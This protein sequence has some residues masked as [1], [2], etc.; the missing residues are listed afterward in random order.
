MQFNP[1]RRGLSYILPLLSPLP[2]Q[3][4]DRHVRYLVFRNCRPGASFLNAVASVACLPAAAAR[5]AATL[6]ST[7]RTAAAAAAAVVAVRPTSTDD[8]RHAFVACRVAHA[9]AASS[10]GRVSCG[11]VAS[12]TLDLIPKDALWKGNRPT[13]PPPTPE[14]EAAGRA[15]A[16]EQLR[17][18][19]ARRFVA[20]AVAA[21]DSTAWGDE[22]AAAAAAAAAECGGVWATALPFSAAVRGRRFPVKA[23]ALAAALLVRAALSLR[24]AASQRRVQVRGTNKIFPSFRPFSPA[25]GGIEFSFSSSGVRVLV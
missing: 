13:G 11:S 21:P 15:A 25:Q 1:F 22:R 7:L 14:T 12:T 4:E 3:S 18:A 23:V 10:L 20:A 19:M 9:A 5:R 16:A 17:Q 8:P 2:S 24:V 6:L